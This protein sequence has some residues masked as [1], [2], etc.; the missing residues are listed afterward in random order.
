M[1]NSPEKFNFKRVQRLPVLKSGKKKPQFEY[2]NTV[3]A[4]DIETT[5]IKKY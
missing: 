5:V 2:L 3:T 1:I 4:F